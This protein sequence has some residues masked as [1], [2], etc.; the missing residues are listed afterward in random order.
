MQI[1]RKIYYHKYTGQVV[2]D[3]GEMSGSVRETTFDEDKVV[4][5][6]IDSEDVAVMTLGYGEKTEQF[7]ES[8]AFVIDHSTKVITF[9]EPVITEPIVDELTVLKEEN[10]Q[11]KI[12]KAEL[13]QQLG[14]KELQITQYETLM[15]GKG[16]P[17]EVPNE[18]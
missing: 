16:E 14:T 5:P 13:I 3:K 12:E 6:E 4:M 8:G 17:L 10:S 2:W 7:M 15:V 11:L 1:G 9:F 18:I